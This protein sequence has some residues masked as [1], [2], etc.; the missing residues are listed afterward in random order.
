MESSRALARHVHCAGYSNGGRFC[1]T[2]ASEL[3]DVV[4]SV[5]IIS[6][7]RYPKPNYAI[8]P[9]PILAPRCGGFVC[10]RFVFLLFFR[11]VLRVAT[12]M[13]LTN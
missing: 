3:S 2:L 11:E 4:A 8:R 7:L 9:V 6:A 12:L 1:V 13:A 10:Q 5:G